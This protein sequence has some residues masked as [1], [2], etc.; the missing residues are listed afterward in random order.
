M[1]PVKLLYPKT[2][3]LNFTKQPK[4]LGKIPIKRT[5][6]HAKTLGN[7]YNHELP[8]NLVSDIPK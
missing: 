3:L 6:I 1:I 4:A 7:Y 2:K 5:S 8:F